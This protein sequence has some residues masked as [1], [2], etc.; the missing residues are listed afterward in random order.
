MTV[1]IKKAIEAA[2]NLGWR[3]MGFL[4]ALPAK[5]GQQAR[6]QSSAA[7]AEPKLKCRAIG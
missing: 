4:L 5:P 6:A 2:S 1:D 3:V 7:A